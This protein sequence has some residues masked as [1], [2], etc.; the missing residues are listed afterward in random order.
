MA[1][2]YRT[3][4]REEKAVEFR[5]TVEDLN[6][7]KDAWLII[8]NNARCYSDSIY[9]VRNNDRDDIYVM[10]NPKTAK[11]TESFL[12]QLGEVTRNDDKYVV[13]VDVECEYSDFDKDYIDSEY[14]LGELD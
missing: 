11:E 7:Y 5:V 8:S 1:R 4:I 2:K 3:H 10:S 6:S 13:F 9:Q 12:L 14:V